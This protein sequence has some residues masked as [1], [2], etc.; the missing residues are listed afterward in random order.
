MGQEYFEMHRCTLLFV[1]CANIAPY[2]HL[3]SVEKKLF[4]MSARLERESS[5]IV[6]IRV[7]SNALSFDG[8]LQLFRVI[9]PFTK[10]ASL[11]SICWGNPLSSKQYSKW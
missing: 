4:W 11:L 3:E 10:I 7:P 8:Y 5:S 2:L 9:I 6:L 1:R